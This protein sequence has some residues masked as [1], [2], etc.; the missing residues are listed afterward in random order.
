[1]GTR[2]QRRAE[3]GWTVLTWLALVA[4]RLTTTVRI[5][6]GN[7]NLPDG[8]AVYVSKH[9]SLFDVIWVPILFRALGRPARIAVNRRFFSPG[10][11]GWLL[12]NLGCVPFSSSNKDEAIAEMV[13]HLRAGRIVGVMPEGRIVPSSDVPDCGFAQP[14]P[15]ASM[16]AIEADVPVVPVS[17]VGAEDAWPPGTRLPRWFRRKEVVDVRPGQPLK[18]TSNDHLATVIH[19]MEAVVAGEPRPN[20]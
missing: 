7:A 16:I 11:I 6:L 3:T 5:D 15:G 4:S 19:A 8:P 9:R 10:P 1:M 17:V 18:P 12:R 14:R 2:S 13:G 20:Q